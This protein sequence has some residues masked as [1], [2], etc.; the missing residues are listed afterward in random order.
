[1]SN[2]IDTS[3]MNEAEIRQAFAKCFV[4]REGKI[5]LSF[6]HR[7]T[8]EHYLGPECSAEH[9]RHLEGQRHLVCYIKSLAGLS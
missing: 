1:M 8:L 4:S 7:I 9:L 2:N 6:L 3:Q 5:V